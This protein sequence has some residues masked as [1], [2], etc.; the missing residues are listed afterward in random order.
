MLDKQNRQMDKKPNSKTP[1]DVD[2]RACPECGAAMRRGRTTLHFERGGFYADVDNVN[3]MLCSRCGTRSVPG[4]TALKISEMVER[5]F[6][7]GK[8]LDMTGISFHKLAS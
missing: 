7:A 4:K 6:S 2:G 1:K 3:A 8:D 5:L